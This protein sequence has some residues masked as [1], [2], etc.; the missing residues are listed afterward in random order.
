MKVYVCASV[1]MLITDPLAFTCT[2]ERGIN[3]NQEDGEAG[4]GINRHGLALLLSCLRVN[5]F[6]T[7]VLTKHNR[8]T[9]VGTPDV[10]VLPS[11]VKLLKGEVT[12]S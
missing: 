12:F 3:S 6:E 11:M 10:A 7:F 9:V 4:E 5:M 8:H 2:L 1:A